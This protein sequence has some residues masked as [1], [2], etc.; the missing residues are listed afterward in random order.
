MQTPRR[1]RRRGRKLN[2]TRHSA[3][4]GRQTNRKVALG[5][6]IR[7]AAG[8]GSADGGG[9]GVLPAGAGDRVALED[10]AGGILDLLHA[11]LYR[12]A[13]ELDRHDDGGGR[14][15]Y[16]VCVRWERV[17]SGLRDRGVV[18]RAVMRLGRPVRLGV[19]MNGGL[20]GRCRRESSKRKT[21]RPVCFFLLCVRSLLFLVGWG[22]WREEARL[23][24][25]ARGKLGHGSFDGQL[26]RGEGVKASKVSQE[27]YP[28]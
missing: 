21:R 11:A 19:R 17:V 16:C 9:E 4:E 13:L 2:R 27:T 15:C 22:G 6:G 20:V 12:L 28:P 1:R 26:K 7:L 18:N 10:V 8:D 25:L 3:R 14:C 5:A 24:W 23:H